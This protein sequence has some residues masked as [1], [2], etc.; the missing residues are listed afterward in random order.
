[1]RMMRVSTKGTTPRMTPL[2]IAS[3]GITSLG[4]LIAGGLSGNPILLGA[5][6]ATLLLSCGAILSTRREPTGTLV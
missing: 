5:G 3:L 1:M 4:L 2:V 6:V